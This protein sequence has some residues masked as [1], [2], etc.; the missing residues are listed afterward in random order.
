MTFCI[1]IFLFVSFGQH[2]R[3]RGTI[4]EPH[5][6]VTECRRGGR[7]AITTEGRHG[8][9]LIRRK[10]ASSLTQICRRNIHTMCIGK[11]TTIRP[12]WIG[13]STCVS[14]CFLFRTR[15]QE[16]GRRTLARCGRGAGHGS[17]KWYIG[18]KRFLLGLNNAHS[19]YRVSGLY[20]A[21]VLVAGEKLGQSIVL[22]LEPISIL[23]ST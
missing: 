10:K 12:G 19:T 2:V 22:T 9:G 11:F 1:F 16:S 6:S 5:L 23:R 13:K 20:R 18:K 3:A 8:L 15:R 21:L 14:V 4:P 17:K 7:V